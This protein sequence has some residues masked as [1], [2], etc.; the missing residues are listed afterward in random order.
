MDNDANYKEYLKKHDKYHGKLLK[1]HGFRLLGSGQANDYD[2]LTEYVEQYNIQNFPMDKMIHIDCCDCGKQEIKYKYFATNNF[3]HS[4]HYNEDTFLILG[5]TCKKLFL[6]SFHDIHDDDLFDIEESSIEN[7]E[8][9]P[10]IRRKYGLDT[11]F[12]Y[13]EEDISVAYQQNEENDMNSFIDDRSES[14]LTIASEDTLLDK[15]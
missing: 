4:S 15:M 10:S 5:S 14:E 1:D 3:K 9:V 13:I 8:V 12:D 7:E 11:I 6:E 2:A